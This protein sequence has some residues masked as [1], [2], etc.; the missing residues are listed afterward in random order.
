MKQITKEEIVA[1]M[2]KFYMEQSK[3]RPIE[4]TYGFFDAMGVLRD[5]ILDEA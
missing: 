3:D 4:Y 2:N 5:L 1:A